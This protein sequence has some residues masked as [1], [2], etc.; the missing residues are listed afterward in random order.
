MLLPPDLASLGR[1]AMLKEGRGKSKLGMVSPNFPQMNLSLIF[2]EHVSLFLYN[3][4][5]ILIS[6]FARDRGIFK[7]RFGSMQ[8]AFGPFLQ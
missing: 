8:A 4:L 2:P 1:V 5:I 6:S 7:D 3:L